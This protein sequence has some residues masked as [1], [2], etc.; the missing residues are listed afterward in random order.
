MRPRILGTIDGILYDYIYDNTAEGWAAAWA[1]FDILKALEAES[2]SINLQ[3][4]GDAVGESCIMV[5][6][7]NW[8]VDE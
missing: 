2:G 6:L 7:A 1:Q 4:C 8:S 5:E 3:F